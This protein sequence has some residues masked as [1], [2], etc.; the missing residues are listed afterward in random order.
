MPS[1]PDVS[2]VVPTFNRAGRLR[3]LVGR[4]RAQHAP[5]LDFEVLIV[6]NA[7]SDATREMVDGLIAGDVRFHYLYEP[8]RGASHARNA[9][10]ARARGSIIAFLDDDVV[11]ATDWLQTL[12]AEFDANPGAD[13]IGGRV[14]GDWPASVP[15][16]LTP[17]HLAPLALQTARRR[18][19]D[20][21][22]ASA[23]LITAN[24]ACRRQVFDDVGGFSTAFMRDEDREFNLRLW[25]AGK[26]G[27]FAD[28]VRV[29]APVDPARLTKPYHRR[30]Y[31]TTGE[32]H[33]RLRYREIIDA[34]GRLV[35]PMTRRCVLGTP[36]FVYRECLA[37]ALRW[38]WSAARFR[39]ADAFYYEC[40][41]R[42]FLSYIAA[43]ARIAACPNDRLA[44]NAPTR[45]KSPN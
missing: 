13:C 39:R 37:E 34:D 4:L 38:L 42:Y 45:A 23:C 30:W 43:R 2:V 32:N 33:A 35:P 8:K 20:A 21:D 40:R 19:F 12:K 10:I 17:R 11:P 16:W 1:P 29:V 3:P 25:R 27:L 24:F 26:R 28:D 6:D 22:H 15:R 9:G 5:G 36:A 44:R 41:V 31:Q 18:E 14:D 7:S